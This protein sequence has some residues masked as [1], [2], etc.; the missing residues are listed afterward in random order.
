MLENLIQ[1]LPPRGLACLFVYCGKTGRGNPAP[2]ASQSFKLKATGRLWNPGLGSPLVYTEPQSTVPAR[3]GSLCPGVCY[4]QRLGGALTAPG[5]RPRAGSLPA[6]LQPVL[7][8]PSPCPRNTT[9][10][11]AS[12]F[13]PPCLISQPTSR[14][15][16]AG[17]AHQGG[18]R[19]QSH[20]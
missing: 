19:K 11:L 15:R 1:L 20:G 3:P 4:S 10:S 9:V 12:G 14:L 8:R 16:G 13:E 17:S 5:P 2:E 6:G 7:P 18:D